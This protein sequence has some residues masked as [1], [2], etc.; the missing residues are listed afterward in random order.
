[1]YFFFL[2][3]VCT[4]GML[5]VGTPPLFLGTAQEQFPTSD[6]RISQ[7]NLLAPFWNDHDGRNPTSSV[8][9]RMYNDAA[10][11]RDLLRSVSS[12]IS[13]NNDFVP[14][15]MLVASWRNVPPYPHTATDRGKVC[16]CMCV[17]VCVCVGGEGG[18]C[19]LLS[20]NSILMNSCQHDL[21]LEDI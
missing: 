21:K 2:M 10:E 14:T 8:T 1:M 13:K 11:D 18:V 3:Q 17:C 6:V 15:W 12:F 19:H 7:S 4:N 5:T 9:Y 16:A 20:K